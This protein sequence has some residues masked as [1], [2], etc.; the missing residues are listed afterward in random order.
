[1]GY[2]SDLRICLYQ[3]PIRKQIWNVANW[4]VSHYTKKE[5]SYEKWYG[6]KE[7]D[8][9][10]NVIVFALKNFIYYLQKYSKYK[11]SMS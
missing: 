7:V 4:S 10:K 1:M 6:K 5:K 2:D 9:Y 8:C 11:S 3:D